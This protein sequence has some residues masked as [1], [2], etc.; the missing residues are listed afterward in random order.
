MKLHSFKE[1]KFNY[2]FKIKIN[3]YYIHF[4]FIYINIISLLQ[5]MQFH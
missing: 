3:I 1:A 2:L 5:T 4:N